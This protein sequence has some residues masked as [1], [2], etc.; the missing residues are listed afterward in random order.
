MYKRKL[1]ELEELKEDIQNKYVENFKLDNNS[2]IIIL[3][4]DEDTESTVEFVTVIN[5]IIS[6]GEK[7]NYTFIGI[8]E[9]ATTVAEDLTLL[10]FTRAR[11]L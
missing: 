3:D 4:E 10:K 5:L 7:Y 9:I 8:S 11:T 6:L 2:V 1:E